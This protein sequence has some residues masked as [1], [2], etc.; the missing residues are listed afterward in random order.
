ME[1]LKL[2]A[3]RLATV[4]YKNEPQEYRDDAVAEAD[5][6]SEV[7]KG[8]SD[9]TLRPIAPERSRRSARSQQDQLDRKGHTFAWKNIALDIKTSDGKKRLLDNI[10]GELP[11]FCMEFAANT[12]SRLGHTGSDDGF[13][14]C[15]GSWKSMDAQQEHVSTLKIIRLPF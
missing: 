14:G 2:P 8:S 11:M 10:D 13:D 7:E 15:I 6:S 12:R 4:F 3:G 5:I 9:K 1:I